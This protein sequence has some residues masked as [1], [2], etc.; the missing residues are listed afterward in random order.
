MER[1]C[2]GRLGIL[3]DYQEMKAIVTDE[4]CKSFAQVLVQKGVIKPEEA[5]CRWWDW[6]QNK[7]VH[8]RAKEAE[9]LY[10]EMLKEKQKEEKDG[11]KADADQEAWFRRASD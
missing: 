2:P 4:F 6:K 9:I 5:G 3:S 7:C 11:K 8:P 1:L 10:Q